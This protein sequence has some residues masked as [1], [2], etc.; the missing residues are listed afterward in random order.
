MVPRSEVE[1]EFRRAPA[2]RAYL[3][4][5]KLAAPLLVRAPLPGDRFRPLGAPGSRK[6]SDL[7]TDLKVPRRQRE[8]TLVVESAGRI[9]WA[10]GLRIAHDFRITARTR[11]V[12]VLELAPLAAPARAAGGHSDHAESVAAGKAGLALPSGGRPPGLHSSGRLA[13]AAD[14]SPVFTP[15]GPEASERVLFTSAEIASAVARLAADVAAWAGG[16]E[17]LV[18]GILHGSFIFVA[19]LVRRLPGPCR[20]GFLDRDGNPVFRAGAIEGA[21]VLVAEDILDT[22]ESLTRV[23]EKLRAHR[24]A[25]V[26]TCVLFDKPSGRKIQVTPDWAGL[27]V[28]DRWVVGYGLDQEGLFRNLP[29]LTFV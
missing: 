19:D 28:P 24:P 27:L 26:R 7:W 21:L 18:L 23:L 16:R 6:L 22:G 25:E 3:D 4:A 15:S 12:A 9:A 2:G 11:T 8:R 20:I 13:S 5:G 29:Y 17:L 1:S 10:A 14:P